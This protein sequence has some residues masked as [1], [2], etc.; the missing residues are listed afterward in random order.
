MLRALEAY[1]PSDS[2][3]HTPGSGIFIWVEL[4]AETDTMEALKIALEKESIAFIPGQA[5]CVNTHRRAS[6]CMRLNFSNPG[7]ESIKTGIARLA[8]VLA[9]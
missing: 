5:F 9:V 7:V 3:W 6:N 8:S 1:F 2:R 4:S